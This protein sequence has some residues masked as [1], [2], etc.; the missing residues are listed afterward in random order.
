MT[1]DW[2]VKLEPTG[3][4]AVAGKEKHVGDWGFEL[5]N[6][7]VEVDARAQWVEA[8]L[9][10]RWLPT[11]DLDQKID[12]TPDAGLLAYTAR[13]EG[14]ARKEGEELAVPVL[15]TYSYMAT[16]AALPKRTL[17]LVLPPQ[18]GPSHQRRAINL[19][20]PAGYSFKELPAGGEAKG[21]AFG[22]AKV[23]FKPGKQAGTVT[24]ESEVIFDKST[25]TV[26]EYPA[27]RKWLESVDALMRKSVRLG[28]SG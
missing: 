28:K 13:S 21:G 19:V 17:P 8:Y 4:A 20:A 1:I 16:F 12:Y 5:R 6:N 26:A 24:I 9:S 23:T 15:G 27:F 18:M 2:T 11:V 22:S 7:L 3:A 10:S 14:Y 25:I